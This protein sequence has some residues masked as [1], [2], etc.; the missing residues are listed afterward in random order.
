MGI[1][2]IQM[3]WESIDKCPDCGS[4]DIEKGSPCTDD[5]EA[6]ERADKGLG[7]PPETWQCNNC[8]SGGGGAN[9]WK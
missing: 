5:F 3:G 6:Q 8:G 1:E 7:L 9:F 2:V 4:S